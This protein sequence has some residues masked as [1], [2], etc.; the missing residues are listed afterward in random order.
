ME[1]VA[2]PRF[3]ITRRSALDMPSQRPLA[4]AVGQ[5]GVFPQAIVG[6]QFQIQGPDTD[7]NGAPDMVNGMPAAVAP[8]DFAIDNLS[9]LDASRV[10]NPQSPTCS[11]MGTLIEPI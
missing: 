10:P 11:N 6:V 1:P 8:F 3:T 4:Q 7:D 2:P 9:F 5:T